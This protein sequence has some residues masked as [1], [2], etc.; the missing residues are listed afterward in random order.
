MKKSL[1]ALA[2]LAAA[3]ATGCA[4]SIE[5]AGNSSIEVKHT[6][7]GKG[8]DLTI[9]DGK[10]YTQGRGIGF[11]GKDCTFQIQESASK[12]FKGQALAVKATGLFT[13]G[14][15]DILAPQDK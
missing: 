8:C 3:G 7:D 13:M 11:D 6:A 14:L 9:K 1:I 10:E 4:T 15:G 2:V 5:Y 12:A